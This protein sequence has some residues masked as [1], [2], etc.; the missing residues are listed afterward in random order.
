MII[1]FMVASKKLNKNETVVTIDLKA[2][3][4]SWKCI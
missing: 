4:I 3:E 1:L 2:L